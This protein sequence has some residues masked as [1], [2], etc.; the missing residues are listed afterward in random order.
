MGGWRGG[1]GG[2]ALGAALDPLADKTLMIG[3]YVTLAATGQLPD[4]LAILVVF[5]D[6]VIVGGI[7]LLWLTGHPAAIRPMRISKANTVLQIVLIA[8]VLGLDA[9][10]AA[11]R[12]AAHRHDLAGRHQHVAVGGGLCAAGRGAAGAGMNDML[13]DELPVSGTQTGAWQ[14]HLPPSTGSTRGQRI[15]LLVGIAVCLWVGL[16]LFEPILMPF[17][18]AAGI[19][20][21]LDPVCT[22]L[23]RAGLPRGLASLVLVLGLVMAVLL[24]ALLLYPLIL[25]QISLLVGR[26][27]SYV[28]GLSAFAAKAIAELQQ[29]LGPEYVDAKLSEL[30]SGQAGAMLGFVATAVSQIVGGGYALFNVLSL[31]VVT[32]VVAFYLLRD[33][34]RV[35]ARADGWLPRR[36][37]GVL[38]AQIREVDRI[39]VRLGA[40]PGDVLHD[41]GDLLCPGALDRRAGPWPGGWAVRG[42]SELHPLCRQHHRIRRRDRPCVCA[43]LHVGGRDPGG[44]RVRGGAGA[45]RLRDLPALPWRPRGTAGGLGDFRAVRGRGGVWV[46]GGDACGAGGGDRGGVGAVLVAAVFAESVVFGSAFVVGGAGGVVG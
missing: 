17:V 6:V 18:A 8:L 5:R 46:R 14:P 9:A 37:Q 29:H 7:V 38:R 12:R 35:V 40:W 16:R 1:R 28:R 13:P 2:T 25:E 22:R 27:P 20:Y 43:V 39:L 33:W 3:M 32:P 19:A 34:P 24:F 4:W 31:V 30:V 45:R 23:A 11:G 15:A 10:G 21:V 26:V 42:V 36:Y 41:P 44:Q